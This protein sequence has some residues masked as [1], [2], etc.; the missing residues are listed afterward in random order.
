MG[1]I[2]TYSID[3]VPTIGD[4]VIGT[5]VQDLN[6]TKNYL[7][8]DVLELGRYE[9][10]LLLD[11][12]ADYEVTGNTIEAITN[13]DLVFT[14]P[15][16]ADAIGKPFTLVSSIAGTTTLAA[17]AGEFI[18]G[19]ASMTIIENGWITVISNGTGWKVKSSV[20]G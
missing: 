15:P 10:Y 3:A 7:I 20:N 5:D 4:K 16:A 11:A 19:L 12:N 13:A 17:D 1:K 8:S 18:N 9:D 6:K 2:A 14:L